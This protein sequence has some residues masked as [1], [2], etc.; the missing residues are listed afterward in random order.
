[1]WH[2]APRFAAC[3]AHYRG[4][5]RTRAPAAFHD[6][7]VQALNSARSAYATAEA[8]NTT[9]LQAAVQGGPEPGVVFA[10]AGRRLHSAR[11][12]L[13]IVNFMISGSD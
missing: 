7:F 10:L 8:A 13:N 9:P 1:V 5:S 4:S 6:Q 3:V 12:A 11:Q 2:I